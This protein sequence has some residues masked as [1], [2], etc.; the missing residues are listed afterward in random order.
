MHRPLLVITGFIVLI[1]A[2]IGIF[3]A[4]IYAAQ[5][6]NTNL[7]IAFFGTVLIA[8]AFIPHDSSQTSLVAFLPTNISVLQRVNIYA[9]L[10]FTASAFLALV[11]LP[12]LV[13]RFRL[14]MSAMMTSRINHRILEPQY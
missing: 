12:R 6:F 10:I 7:V 3:P 4:S 8:F 14:R 13:S 5:Q 9:T 2:I 11:I 1:L